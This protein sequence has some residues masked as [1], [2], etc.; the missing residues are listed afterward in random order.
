MQR[1]KRVL[2]TGGTGG[3]GLGI[4]HAFLRA[5]YRVVATGLTD[6]EIAAVEPQDGLS[7]AKLDVTDQAAI[8][9]LRRWSCSGLCGIERRRRAAYQIARF[10]VGA[11][12]YSRQCRRSRM[13]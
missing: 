7:L 2:V 4:A 5:G 1:E 6:A 9:R 10:G 12:R 11:R 13:D 8:D 3:I